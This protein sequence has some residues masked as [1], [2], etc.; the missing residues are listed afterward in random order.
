MN[1]IIENVKPLGIKA[2]VRYHSKYGLYHDCKFKLF[3]FD[4]FIPIIIMYQYFYIPTYIKVALFNTNNGQIGIRV[5]EYES[6]CL[7]EK[8][9]GY[10]ILNIYGKNN[11]MHT[12]VPIKKSFRSMLDHLTNSS[13]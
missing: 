3:I 10:N 6:G 2:L 11:S 9:I 1:H 12:S 8:K 5:T 4:D 13:K 7:F